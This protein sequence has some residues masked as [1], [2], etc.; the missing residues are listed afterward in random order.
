MS[1]WRPFFLRM[2]TS[3]SWVFYKYM[4]Y[5]IYR[6][7]TFEKYTLTVLVHSHFMQLPLVFILHTC[8][9]F[10]QCPWASI[11]FQNTFKILTLN[12]PWSTSVSVCLSVCLSVSVYIYIYMHNIYYIC[13]NYISS[14][15]SSIYLYMHLFIYLYLYLYLSNIFI[16]IP[17]SYTC[18]CS[19]LYLSINIISI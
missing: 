6:M 17:I 5:F 2:G 1:V 8:C 4:S 10:S 7:R 14:L 12:S 13:N 11:L 19:Y 16:S 15:I 18:L 3:L 9:E